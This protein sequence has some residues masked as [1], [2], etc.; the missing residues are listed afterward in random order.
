MSVAFLELVPEDMR[1]KHILDMRETGRCGFPGHVRAR[2]TLS[3]PGLTRIGSESDD[4]G[5]CPAPNRQAMGE[6]VLE[7]DP[8]REALGGEDSHV[9]MGDEISEATVCI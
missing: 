3:I 8:Q 6:R 4:G 2:R 1:Q 5:F 7:R 9:R